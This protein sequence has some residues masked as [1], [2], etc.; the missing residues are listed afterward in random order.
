MGLITPNTCLSWLEEK[1]VLLTY[2]PRFLVP[3][4]LQEQWSGMALYLHFPRLSC[5]LEPNASSRDCFSY[6]RGHMEWVAC[7]KL[8]KM[9]SPH[10][11]GPRGR[12]LTEDFSYWCIATGILS[13]PF[14]LLLPGTVYLPLNY[15]Q[16]ENQEPRHPCQG[17]VMDNANSGGVGQE[18]NIFSHLPLLNLPKALKTTELPLM[19]KPQN[20]GTDRDE[21]TGKQNGRWGSSALKDS[22]I[23]VRLCSTNRDLCSNVTKI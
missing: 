4:P 19:V 5:S 23:S 12:H 17:L 21:K 20:K 16:G 13:L 14:G 1:G 18:S 3:G 8:L 22:R 11:S 6:F 10:P 15:Q 2:C 7:S 9:A